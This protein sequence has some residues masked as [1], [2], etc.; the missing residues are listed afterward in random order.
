MVSV[1]FGPT[2]RKARIA[3]TM[4][5]RK[6]GCWKR[7]NQRDSGSKGKMSGERA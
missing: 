6:K 5:G 7:N 1:K 2:G 4:G 3:F